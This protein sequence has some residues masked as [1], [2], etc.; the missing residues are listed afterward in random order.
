MRREGSVSS[1]K[2]T[3]MLPPGAQSWTR[4]LRNLGTGERERVRFFLGGLVVFA[5]AFALE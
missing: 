5:F 1:L 4:D 3:I 2:E